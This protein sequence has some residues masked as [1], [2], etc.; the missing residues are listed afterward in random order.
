MKTIAIRKK[1]KVKGR[2]ALNLGENP[3]SKGLSFSRSNVNFFLSPMPR[4]LT[5]RVRVNTVK[6]KVVRI[7]IN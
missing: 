4:R 3:H 6:R 2:R 5:T 7:I 1:R